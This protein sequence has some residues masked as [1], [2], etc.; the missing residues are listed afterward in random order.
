[1]LFAA[2]HFFMKTSIRT[3]C[4]YEQQIQILESRGLS[5]NKID[6]ERAIQILHCVNYYKIIN[7]YKEFFT[8]NDDFSGVDFNDIYTIYKFD[9]KLRF[10]IT[11]YFRI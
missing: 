10:I 7:G 2:A 11:I 8:H 4:T 1:M 9:D 5:F 3:F 6:K